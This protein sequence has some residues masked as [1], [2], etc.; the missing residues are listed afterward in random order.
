MVWV[1][2]GC[3]CYGSFP[4]GVAWLRPALT[5]AA[6]CYQS[7]LHALLVWEKVKTQNSEYSSA[8]CMLLSQHG[9]VEKS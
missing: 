4:L 8:K 7:A 1:Q 6:L 9:Q 2:S 5:A 3:K